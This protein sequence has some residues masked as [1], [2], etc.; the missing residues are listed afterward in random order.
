MEVKK[1]PFREVGHGYYTIWDGG[2]VLS[3]SDQEANNQTKSFKFE[4]E[5]II[6]VRYMPLKER[7]VFEKRGALWSRK[8]EMKIA[9]PAP[10]ETYHLCAFLSKVKDNIHIQRLL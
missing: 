9:R 6:D 7:V 5:D 8:F 1:I 2:W 10:G 4:N 3:D